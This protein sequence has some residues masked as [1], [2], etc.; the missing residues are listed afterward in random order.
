MAEQKKLSKALNHRR[1]TKQQESFCRLV[2]DGTPVTESVRTVYVSMTR[3][4]S[5]GSNMMKIGKVKARI[6]ELAK[7]RQTIANLSRDSLTV[8]ALE[9][10][11]SARDDKSYSAAISG[12]RLVGDLQG[13]CQ[14]SA[15]GAE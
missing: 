3:P 15:S 2:A 6:E 4:A 13:F 1:L 5:F 14:N 10:A 7:Q 9:T 11:E 12:L 8:A